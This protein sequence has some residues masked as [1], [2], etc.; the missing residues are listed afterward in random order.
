MSGIHKR[1]F[2]II[3]CSLLASMTFVAS[4]WVLESLY[5]PTMNPLLSLLINSLLIGITFSATSKVLYRKNIKL[6]KKENQE[7][8]ENIDGLINKISALELRII[9]LRAENQDL[10]SG[11]QIDT[12]GP[13]S[14]N[15]FAKI[16]YNTSKKN[17]LIAHERAFLHNLANKV[18][19]LQLA[20]SSISD[21]IEPDQNKN[22]QHI[23]AQLGVISNNIEKISD[24]LREN[25]EYLIIAI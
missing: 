8:K 20:A 17:S 25:R 7:S 22:S 19:I 5:W 6:F 11:N 10:K 23:Q 18:Q 2:R 1:L 9:D 14:K 15:E 13:T 3:F 21:L 12:I 16:S 4:Y 24:L